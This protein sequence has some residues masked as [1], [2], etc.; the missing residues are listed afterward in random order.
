M[1]IPILSYFSNVSLEKEKKLFQ[2]SPKYLGHKL[3]IPES[4]NFQI[5]DNESRIL[6]NDNNEIKILSNVCRHRQSIILIGKGSIENIVCPLHRWT[7]STDG[8]LIG[9]PHFKNNFQLPLKNFSFNN[10]GGMLFENA[11]D[12]LK[13]LKNFPYFSYINFSDYVYHDHYDYLA[14]YNWKTFIEVFMDDYHVLPTHLGLGSFVDCNNIQWHSTET[15]N[16]QSVGLE[17]LNLRSTENYDKWKDAIKDEFQDNIPKYGAIW[18]TIF[19]N[20]MIE[21]YPKILVITTLNPITPQS[22]KVHAEFYYHNDIHYFNKNYIEC[23]QAAYRETANE[24][25]ELSRKIDS[26]RKILF[27]NNFDD[28]GPIHQKLEI[29]ITDF[30][31]F[32]TKKIDYRNV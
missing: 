19:P 29:G 24:D 9:C 4:K 20:I 27:D 11:Q 10:W 15:Y 3:M 31:N 8:N 2:S 22:T 32:L 6:I 16:I 5:I 30:H 7:Y 12:L 13:D 25:D 28:Y 23:H 14:D 1:S 26:G 17:D 18:M 21:W